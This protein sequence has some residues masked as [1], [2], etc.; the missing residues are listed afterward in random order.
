M[1]FIASFPHVCAGSCGM[2]SWVL[3]AWYLEYHFCCF[4]RSL[5]HDVHCI[6]SAFLWYDI[7]GCNNFLTRGKYK[8]ALGLCVDTKIYAALSAVTEFQL[9]SL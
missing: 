6:I 8:V 3:V 7:S 5:W 1:T 9:I 2:V 4:V